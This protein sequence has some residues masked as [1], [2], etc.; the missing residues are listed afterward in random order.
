VWE[1]VNRE[2]KKRRKVM[3]GIEMAEWKEHFMRLLRGW[4]AG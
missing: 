1:I 2:R 4:K 3:E